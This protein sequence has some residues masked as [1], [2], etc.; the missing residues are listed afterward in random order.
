MFVS[1]VF[2][3][4]FDNGTWFLTS[5]R[6]RREKERKNLVASAIVIDK[7]HNSRGLSVW[8][9]LKRVN[10][11]GITEGSEDDPE[12]RF[13]SDKP[14][15]RACFSEKGVA[16]GVITSCPGRDRGR[17]G[18]RLIPEVYQ[19]SLT[20]PSFFPSQSF[21]YPSRVRASSIDASACKRTND[22]LLVLASFL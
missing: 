14:I 21:I 4:N 8:D 5:R 9:N 1:I 16:Y 7:I 6:S 12:E 19:D 3:L 2:D 22:R 10:Q 17:Y 15:S 11:R 18:G 20:V 13:R